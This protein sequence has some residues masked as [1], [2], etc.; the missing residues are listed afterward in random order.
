MKRGAGGRGL[1]AAPHVFA[2]TL[3]VL[4]VADALLRSFAPIW[5]SVPLTFPDRG[6]LFVFC[7]LI[8]CAVGVGLL[9]RRTAVAAAGLLA[10]VLL[11]WLVIFKLRVIF[12]E[13]IRAV[14][15]ESFGETAVLAA[16]AWVLCLP[17][18]PAP[19]GR[20]PGVMHGPWTVR[21][22]AALLGFA[23]LAFGVAHFAYLHETAALVPR[24]LPRP[25]FW[26]FLFGCT[27]LAAGVAILSGIRA[28]L[29]AMLVTVQMALF[30]ILVWVPAALATFRPGDW[31]E[32]A[33]SWM[34]TVA[35][36]VV[37]ASYRG[38]LRRG[39]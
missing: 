39:A 26:A 34:L 25:V 24:W 22:T 38:S 21:V 28:P 12:H 31:R 10:A 20:G 29:A 8:E 1:L 7:V 2:V 35:A 11:L 37:A 14:S 33:D 36:W 6:W 19:G 5:Q 17:Q 3:V 32:L 15:Y 4:G 13:P 27:Y 30:T 23:L 16:A 9:Y 18:G